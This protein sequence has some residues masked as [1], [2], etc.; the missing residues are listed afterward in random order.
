MK[1][2]LRGQEENCSLAPVKKIA[3]EQPVRSEEDLEPSEGTV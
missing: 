2:T 1:E 3:K